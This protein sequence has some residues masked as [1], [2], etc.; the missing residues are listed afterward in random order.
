M[1][2]YIE[3]EKGVGARHTE[4][5]RRGLLGTA[6][7]EEWKELL[8]DHRACVDYPTSFFYKVGSIRGFN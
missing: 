4:I 8:K 5:L 3:D 7:K 1:I 6:T 2:A